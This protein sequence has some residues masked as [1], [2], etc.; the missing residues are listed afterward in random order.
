VPNRARQYLR[1]FSVCLLFFLL[2]GCGGQVSF[3]KIDLKG[4]V[5]VER[6]GRGYCF[7]VPKD[8]E[9]R[10]ALEG[11]DVVC[12]APPQDGFRDSVVAK[13]LSASQLGDPKAVVAK[14]LESLGQAVTVVEPWSQPDIPLVV[15]LEEGHLS[16]EPLGQLLFLHLKADGSGIL[17]TCTTTK[18]K[19]AERRA[20][21][22]DIFAGAKYELE[23][24]TGP[25]GLPKVFPTPEVTLT[26]E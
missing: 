18:H 2:A 23:E 20:F 11:A 7:R 26:P 9:I 4:H 1:L 8:W 12:L 14:Q 10:E 6:D 21:F 22:S 3:E 5:R 24:C 13:T 19:L 15:T 16:K 25:G 17:I